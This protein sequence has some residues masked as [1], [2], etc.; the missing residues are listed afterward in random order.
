MS[1]LF[2]TPILNPPLGSTSTRISGVPIRFYAALQI[3]AG[4][5]AVFN[6]QE[7][8][9]VLLWYSINGRG[10]W[11]PAP[12]REVSANTE[13]VVKMVCDVVHIYTYTYFCPPGLKYVEF[14]IFTESI[15]M[16]MS[17]PLV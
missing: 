10:T 1:N 6:P 15:L 3:V 13:D 14:K 7:K 11:K 12:F 17:A 4:S 8:F 5:T 16:R 9:T 2:F